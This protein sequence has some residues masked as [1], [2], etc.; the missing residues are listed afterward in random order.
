[1]GIGDNSSSTCAHD[2]TR[3][4][5]LAGWTAV[6]LLP[7]E[8]P[9]VRQSSLTPV[10]ASVPRDAGQGTRGR[11]AGLLWP[12]MPNWRSRTRSRTSSDRSARPNGS[13]M[14]NG[15][16][17]DPTRCSATS[18]ATPTASP[19]RTGG[20]SAADQHH[21]AFR[22]KDYRVAQNARLRHDHAERWKTMTLRTDEFI[23]RF[24]SHVLPKGFHRI[25][26]YGLIANGDR[27]ANVARARQL[28]D[29]PVPAREPEGDRAGNDLTR[30]MFSHSPVP[31]AAG[32]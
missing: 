4:R 32:A 22:Y 6:D 9:V 15:H 23:R 19:S 25:R 2:R 12:A 11:A 3:R 28:L 30:R 24:L 7:G 13:S 17:V 16:S 14:P 5:H 29:L 20:W 27:V 21:V 8:L 1:M 26:H 10:P 31:A 18:H